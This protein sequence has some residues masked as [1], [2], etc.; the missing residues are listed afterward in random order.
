M[1]AVHT[2]SMDASKVDVMVTV[3]DSHLGKIEDVAQALR[4]HGMAVTS[5]LGITGVITGSVEGSHMAALRT[6]P[7]V[8][9]VEVQGEKRVV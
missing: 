1:L 9:A 5:V 8:T 4:G 7:G 3:G 2:A 6:V